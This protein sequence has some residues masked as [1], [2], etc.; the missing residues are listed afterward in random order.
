MALLGDVEQQLNKRSHLSRLGQ[1][2]DMKACLKFGDDDGIVE[3]GML[4][5]NCDCTVGACVLAHSRQQRRVNTLTTMRRYYAAVGHVV[6]VASLHPAAG[7]ADQFL[8]D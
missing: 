5:A 8:A 3:N 2:G 4:G 6:D 7:P 1:P